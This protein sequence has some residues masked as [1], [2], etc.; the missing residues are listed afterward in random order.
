[1]TNLATCP[2]CQKEVPTAVLEEAHQH[3][4]WIKPDGA[5][6]ACVQFNLLH[7]LLSQGDAALHEQIQTEWPLDAKA[8]FGALPTPLRLHAD[9]RFT[10]QGVTIAML[11]SDFYPHPDL[12]RPTNRIRAWVDITSDPIEVITFSPDEEPRWPGWDA[13]SGSQWHGTMT[14]VSAAGNGY[15]SHG[16]YSGLA[17]EAD[18]VLLR[19]RDETG[20]H[21]PMIERALRWVAENAA[22]FNIRVANMSFGGDPVEELWENPVDS[23]VADLVAQGITVTA[24]AGN[25]GV[26]WLVPPATAPEGLTIGG[27]DDRNTFDHEDDA[28]WHSNYGSGVDAAFK[29]EL[30]A[31]SIWLA[32][33]VLPGTEVAW[34]A[35]F[36]FQYRGYPPIEERI[37]QLKLITPHYQ[38]VDGTSFAAPLVASTIACMLQANPSLTPP[39]IRQ[40]L[41]QTATPI[42]NV[43]RERQGSGAVTPGTAVAVALHHQHHSWDDWTELPFVGAENIIF[44]LHDH[45]VSRVRLLGSWDSWQAAQEATRVEEG[46][47]QMKLPRLTDG[48]Y[49]YKFLLD[50]NYWLDDPANPRK[51]WDGYGG[52]NS[53]LTV[54]G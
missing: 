33:P 9:P 14:A 38:H 18:L 2:T 28:A 24:A 29:P 11:D 15:L 50:D 27:L 26:R 30:V 20:I 32:A 31:P 8:A 52:F 16:L 40:I 5:C 46:V 36:L 51:A 22:E 47:W 23:A 6:P 48:R 37:Q 10:G 25:D 41:Q 21:N 19:V 49:A 12:T 4:F 44:V 13:L 3:S 7:T 39:L 45:S 1:M 17:R 54:E 43:S 42:P 35:K 34:E 53:L